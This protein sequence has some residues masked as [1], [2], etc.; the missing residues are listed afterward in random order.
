MSMLITY[1]LIILHLFAFYLKMDHVFFMIKRKTMTCCLDIK[2]SAT[3]LELRKKVSR[4]LHKDFE[5]IKLLKDQ[6]V[7]CPDS[8]RDC[9][10]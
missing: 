4:I 10:T 3:V 8:G 7:S 5:D 1:T 2:E 9:K 6:Q